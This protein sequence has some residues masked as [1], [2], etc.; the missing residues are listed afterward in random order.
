MPE[1]RLR[2]LVVGGAGYIGS[3]VVRRL[4]TDGHSVTALDMGL[5]GFGS[6]E[7]IASNIILI[8]GDA[9][10]ETVARKALENIDAVVYLAE[11]VGDPA[12]KL[13]PKLA[14]SINFDGPCQFARLAKGAGIARFIYS[15]SCSVYGVA[16][17]DALLTEDSP[18][19][20]ASLYAELKIQTEN[21]LRSIGSEHFQPIILRFATAHGLS[22]RPRFDLVVNVLTARAVV[23]KNIVIKGGQ[24]WR[25]LIHVQDIAA[26]VSAML[27]HTFALPGIQIFNVGFSDENYT[28]LELGTI[29]EK[30]VPGTRLSLLDQADEDRRSYRVDFSHLQKEFGLTPSHRVA[31]SVE[32]LM[33]YIQTHQNYTDALFS[34]VETLKSSA[35]CV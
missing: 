23:E 16:P 20:P 10:D 9:R 2:V 15:S 5:Y 32:E 24:E 19:H 3:M 22:Y 26:T 31:D 12:C 33:A 21:Y 11:I 7:S 4:L 14:T 6:L 28:I 17:N 30:K 34:N 1:K 8:K 29:V 18:L 27:V 13:C 35:L 25:P